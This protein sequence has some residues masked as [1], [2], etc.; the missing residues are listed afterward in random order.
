[1]EVLIV[2]DDSRLTS[3]LSSWLADQGLPNR[4]VADLRGARTA[5]AAGGVDAIVLDAMLPDGDGFDFLREA[6]RVSNIPILLLTGRG[7]DV[8]RI[9]G[10]EL[11][12]DDYLAKPFNPRELLARLRAVLR[13]SKPA[14][15]AP[16]RLTVD[17]ESLRVSLDGRA[18]P[19]T[20]H[21]FALLA[22]LAERPGKVWSR[23]ALLERLHHGELHVTERTIDVH[24]ARIRAA[25]GDQGADI[26]KTLRGSGY[27]FAAPR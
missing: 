24:V 27:T 11:G 7:D 9:V 21:Q 25:L 12:A 20:A 4:V 1:V 23:E 17:A 10:L 26:V 8:D 3:M 2:D 22:V 6:R 18:V 16:S 14:T 19:L 5:L 13:R 15:V